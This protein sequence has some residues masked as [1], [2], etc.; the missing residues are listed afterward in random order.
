MIGGMQSWKSET[1]G[2]ITYVMPSDIDLGEGNCEDDPC[3]QIACDGSL[4][5]FIVTDEP[6]PPA[7]GWQMATGMS[8]LG[9][10]IVYSGLK[11][12]FVYGHNYCLP[13]SPTRDPEGDESE[14]ACKARCSMTSSC[15][16][17]TFYQPSSSW[18][19]ELDSH[20]QT[21]H[22][23][24]C[25]LFESCA[26]T[27]VSSAQGKVY[28]K[29][30]PGLR[31]GGNPCIKPCGGVQGPCTWCGSGYCCRSGE[32]GL[33]C[34]GISGGAVHHECVAADSITVS[35]SLSGSCSATRMESCE[36]ENP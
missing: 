27:R 19:V 24:G 9:S 16:A 5:Y 20:R 3:W 32:A 22:R 4:R 7:G 26:T 8:G 1:G 31:N 12:D 6:M 11:Y 17:I 21:T 36:D 14:A 10:P 34:D 18:I 35:R 28:K 15:S 2:L 29:R 13:W 33:G 30:P 25:S 23:Q